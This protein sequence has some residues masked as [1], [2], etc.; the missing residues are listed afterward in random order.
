MNLKEYIFRLKNLP[1]SISFEDTIFIIDK[2]YIFEATE[3]KNA[4]ILNKIDENIGSCKIFAFGLLNKLTE[5]EVLQCF[6]DFYRKDVLIDPCGVNH[7]N[8][9]SFIKNGWS[10]VQFEK[11][12][13]SLKIS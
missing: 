10:G 6:G 1:E 9:R 11:E 7:Q 3:F 2:Y 5:S 8:I 13:L 12:A 4:E